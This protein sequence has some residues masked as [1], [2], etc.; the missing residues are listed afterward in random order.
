MFE[1]YKPQVQTEAEK[2]CPYKCEP[3]IDLPDL[4]STMGYILDQEALEVDCRALREYIAPV[5]NANKLKELA[6][7]EIKERKNN[8]SL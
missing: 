2:S 1:K 8:E 3:R 5:L 4:V 6:T 7:V